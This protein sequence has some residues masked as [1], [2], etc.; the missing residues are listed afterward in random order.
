[1]RVETVD[2]SA[3]ITLREAVIVEGKYDK[4]KLDG[5]LDCLILVTGGFRI[6]QDKEK[7]ALI[8]RLAH[9]CGIVIMTDS[10]AAGQRIRSHIKNIAAG[11]RIINVFVPQLTGKERRKVAPSAEGLLGV[12]GLSHETLRTALAAAGIHADSDAHTQ[13]EEP[14]CKLTH[15]DFY[16]LGLSGGANSAALRRSL[17]LRL[18]FP[19]RMSTSDAVRLLG[20][21]YTRDK[22]EKLLEDDRG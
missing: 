12:E 6:F 18:G 22:L 19:A 9:E 13:I 10:D 8:R 11:G 2:R 15:A 1:M 4:I 3:R 20:G 7:R 14:V 17:L 16:E 21:L 5:L